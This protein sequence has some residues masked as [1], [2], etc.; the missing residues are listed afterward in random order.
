MSSLSDV[1]MFFFKLNRSINYK[2]AIFL[3]CHCCIQLEIC[4]FIVCLFL[5]PLFLHFFSFYISFFCQSIIL[6]HSFAISF[7]SSYF[8]YVCLV[9]FLYFSFFHFILP[10]VCLIL[11]LS[12]LPPLSCCSSMHL[13]FL[14]L[15]PLNKK[16]VQSTRRHMPEDYNHN[17]MYLL[18]I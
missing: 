9:L 8:L 1:V 2:W 14:T 16:L 11:S 7:L 15:L 10:T 17:I 13:F 12:F 5:Y 6:L 18:P 4:I 3:L